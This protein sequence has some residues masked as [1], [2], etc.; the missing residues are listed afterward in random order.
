MSLSVR[1]VPMSPQAF[2][3]YRPIA[4]QAYADNIVRAGTMPPVEARQKA[5]ADFDG[6]LPDG[7]DTA[8]QL[9]W[10]ALDA[11]EEIGMLWLALTETSAGLHAFGYDFGV[12]A[13]H[14]RQGY[15]R[16]I[17]AAAEEICRE[18]GVVEIGLSVFGFNTGAHALYEQMGFEVTVQQMRKRL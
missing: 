3:A 4:E 2:D 14:R 15:G 12:T 8:G 9:F 17:M 13:Q 1:L 10:T 7:V 16:A 6:L 18:R 5:A 11:D